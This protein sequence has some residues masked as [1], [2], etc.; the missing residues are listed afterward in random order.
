MTH[1]QGREE[2][3]KKITLQVVGLYPK[4]KL[5]EGFLMNILFSHFVFLSQLGKALSG[6]RRCI[7]ISTGYFYI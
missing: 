5:K 4:L 6:L 2:T 7:A 1:S 3:C